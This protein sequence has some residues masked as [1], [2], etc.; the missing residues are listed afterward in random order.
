MTRVRRPPG[1]RGATASHL[2]RSSSVATRQ[3]SG[4]R[5]KD[6]DRDDTCKVLDT[7]LSEGQLS[8][9]EHGE[10]VK[11]ATSATTLGDLQALVTDLQTG[12]APVRLPDLTKPRPQVGAGA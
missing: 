8:M 4:T 9:A 5:A 7:A 3:T 11:A 1:H 6:S 10:R 12:N 2:L